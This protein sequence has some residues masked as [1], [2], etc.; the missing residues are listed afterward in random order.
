M[1]IGIIGA[2]AMGCLFA[3]LLNETQSVTLYDVSRETVNAINAHGVRCRETDS[4]QWT[5]AV[6]AALSGTAEAPADLAILFVKDT[7]SRAA[8]CRSVSP[9]ATRSAT[10]R[11]RRVSGPDGGSC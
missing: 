2:G 5:H 9:W 1:K 4:S 11:W 3:G 6:P 7:V 8:I 10:S